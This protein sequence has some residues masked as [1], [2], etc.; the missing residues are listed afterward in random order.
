M[1]SRTRKPPGGIRK[2]AV[3]M[4]IYIYTYIYTY[5][6]FWFG[7]GFYMVSMV[8][9]IWYICWIYK[10]YKRYIHCWT[11]C[12][13]AGRRW[14]HLVLVRRLVRR[15]P[16]GVSRRMNKAL[17]SPKKTQKGLCRRCH[18]IRWSLDEY[19]SITMILW[20]FH[21]SRI[22]TPWGK[23]TK[24]CQ[25]NP[26]FGVRKFWTWSTDGVF[27]TLMLVSRR[28]CKFWWQKIFI[29]ALVNEHSY[30]TWPFIVS[31]PIKNGDF[32]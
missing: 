18:W 2:F 17:Q 25:K 5:G 21:T 14:H 31:F 8:Y 26:W 1:I 12:W 30:W 27:C 15:F 6:R 7:H 22:K 13:I 4:Y 32:P 24:R 19:H 23:P 3:D 9:I 16:V 20:D 29:Y 28:V 10:P 11:S